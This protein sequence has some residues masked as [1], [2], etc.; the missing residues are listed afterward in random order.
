[1]TLAGAHLG[2]QEDNGQGGRGGGG[3]PGRS[4][5]AL[6]DHGRLGILWWSCAQ[7]VRLEK[8]YVWKRNARTSI[9]CFG[10]GYTCTYVG[11][12]TCALYQLENKDLLTR[13]RIKTGCGQWPDCPY[14]DSWANSGEASPE[15]SAV[16]GQIT[17]R[18]DTGG[19]HSSGTTTRAFLTAFSWSD[20]FI[21]S[22]TV[23][24]PCVE[25]GEIGGFMT[26][27]EGA[28]LCGGNH[29]IG[30]GRGGGGWWSQSSLITQICFQ[31]SSRVQCIWLCALLSDGMEVCIFWPFGYWQDMSGAEM[32]EKSCA[33]LQSRVGG[34]GGRGWGVA[35]QGVASSQPIKRSG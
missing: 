8:V 6:L 2:G 5:D 12:W 35:W 19:W 23:H 24:W 28:F 17:V 22:S 32:I 21:L 4:E 7:E 13:V 1:M 15:W 34:V 20:L 33:G 18:S 26:R 9:S 14:P 11:G 25:I 10:M 30:A 31:N 16:L 29:H 27:K 3:A